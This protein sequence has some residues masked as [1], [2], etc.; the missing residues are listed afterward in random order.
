MSLVTDVTEHQGMLT[1]HSITD[2]ASESLARDVTLI[3]L[4]QSNDLMF[5]GTPRKHS[6]NGTHGVVR[7]ISLYN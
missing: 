4:R 7:Y 5:V 6:L 2:S 3:R 1:V